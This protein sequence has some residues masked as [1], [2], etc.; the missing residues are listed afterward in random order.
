MIRK[1]K[2]ERIIKETNKIIAPLYV[3]ILILTCIVAVAKYI[4]LT[5]EVS[6]YI[7]ELIAIITSIGYLIFRSLL[8]RIPIFSS[9]D[10]CIKELQNTYRTNSFYICFWVYIVGEFILVLISGQE[11]EIV[12]FY[13]L[14]WLIPSIIIT[15]KSIKRGLFIWGSKNREKRGMVSFKKR[16][17]L[18]SLFFG[19]F[20]GWS[21]LWN[22]GIFQPMG[23]VWVI[24]RAIGWGIPFYFVM[25]LM[26]SKGEKN[27]DKE[28][29]KA[30]KLNK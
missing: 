20:T 2:D 28:L 27:S 5:H 13:V 24:G 10:E 4:F 8:N 26:I 18:G 30:E 14:I 6:H 15:V 23:I 19:I 1:Q 11:V 16:V 12:G 3:M 7:L 21:N 25:K 17:L 22:D 29:E 9:E